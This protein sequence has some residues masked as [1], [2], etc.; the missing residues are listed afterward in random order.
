MAEH[1]E[2][3]DRQQAQRKEAG[4][5]LIVAVDDDLEALPILTAS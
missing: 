3:S 5:P 1:S 4:L 2:Q